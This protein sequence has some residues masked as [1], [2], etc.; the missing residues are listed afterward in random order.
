MIDRQT[1]RRIPFLVQTL[2]ESLDSLRLLGRRSLLALLGI[3][4]GCAAVIALLNIG[5]N[6]AN[7]SISTFKGL[8]T[9]TMI[10]SFPTQPGSNHPAP[11]TLDIQALSVALPMIEHI[12]PLTLQST[13][14]TY[15]GRTT[16][17]TIAGTSVGLAAALGLRLE[18]GRF[19]SDF[20]R[21][22]TYAV[23]G[24]RVARDLGRSDA[25]LRLGDHLPIEGY[26]FEVIGIAAS[27]APTPF[28]PV[29][30]DESIFVPIEGMRRLQPAP[31]IG[32]IIVRTWDTPD[33]NA[34]ADALKLYLDSRSHRRKAEV[35]VPQHLLDGLARQANTFAYLIAGLGG[36]SLLVGGVGVMNVMLMNVAE[37]RREIGIRMAL[38]AKASDIRNL[39]LLE[40]ATLSIAGALVGAI[41]GLAAAYAFVRI[42]GWSFSLA[43]LSLPLGVCSSLMVGLFFGLHPALAAARLQPV[44]ALRDD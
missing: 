12:A 27:L 32:S 22:T 8:G 35:Q 15:K 28:I 34:A 9:N 37:R 2:I 23:V 11:A 29:A 25:P 7:E 44:Q 13:R 36:I 6:A 10:A 5:H 3:A 20:D 17:A 1:D 21:H 16:D 39:F 42:S 18:Q 40:A 24:A 41:V 31:E 19:L 43:P 30:A 4:V 38:G 14:I 33:L 26:L